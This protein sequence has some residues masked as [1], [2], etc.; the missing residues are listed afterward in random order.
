MLR[1]VLDTN[2]IVS[3]LKS[4]KTP[5]GQI[6][7][8]WKKKQFTFITSPQLLA[9]IHEVLLRPAILE[10][11]EKTPD[12]V[13]AFIKFLIQKTFVTEGKLELN[14]LIND[15]GDN[16][17]LACAQEGLATH[18]VTGNT[19]DFPFKEYKGIRILTPKEFLEILEQK[20]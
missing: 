11:L 17:V 2:V 18:L 5:P 16:M 6:L 4:Q 3:G 15:P 12:E 14:V 20:N 19:K 8:S 10:L 1:A 9:E 7:N 13:N